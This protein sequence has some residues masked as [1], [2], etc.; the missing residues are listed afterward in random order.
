[1]RRGAGN[2]EA[3]FTL[4]EVL[5]SMSIGIVLIYLLSEILNATQ[6]GWA[7]T[8]LLGQVTTQER[9]TARV[10]G[11]ML[12]S[13]LPPAPGEK[14][15]TLI[16]TK[17][18]LEFST[19]PPQSRATVGLLR[20]RLVIEAEEDGLFALVLNLVPTDNTL[21]TPGISSRHVLL[22]GLASAY[23]SYYY[24]GPDSVFVGSG[25]SDV[26]PVLIVVN[27]TY[28]DSGTDMRE[29]AVHQR[30]SLSGRCQ[31]DMTSATCR[32]S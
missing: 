21:R 16:A 15:H 12:G 28:P 14:E 17:E 18:S 31:L 19:L 4:L 22:S 26:A 20:A 6:T 7:R 13:L 8:N 2:T 5:V 10:L 27:W 1:M 23:F 9:R 30:V 11:H 25:R 32:P 29:L 3:G 24:N